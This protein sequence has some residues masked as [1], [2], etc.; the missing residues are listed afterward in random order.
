MDVIIVTTLSHLLMPGKSRLDAGVKFE[1]MPITWG[2][3]H[4]LHA[5]LYLHNRIP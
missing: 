3:I 1:K 2:G 5:A 4:Q